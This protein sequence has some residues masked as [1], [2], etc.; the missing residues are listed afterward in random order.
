MNPKN[1]P[2]NLVVNGLHGVEEVVAVVVGEGVVLDREGQK[3]S[4]REL[5][6]MH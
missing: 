3:S 1:P 5:F 4:V 6:P 2:I